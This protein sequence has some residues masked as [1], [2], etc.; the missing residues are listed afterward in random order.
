[1]K[2]ELFSLYYILPE[3]Q[4]K[5]PEPEGESL[6]AIEA[7]GAAAAFAILS[8]TAP[9]KPSK[10]DDDGEKEGEEGGDKSANLEKAAEKASRKT[11]RR[12]KRKMA[13]E[14][15]VNNVLNAQT[16]QQLMDEVVVFENA[17]PSQ[18]VFAYN[19]PTPSNNTAYSLSAVATRLYTI[20]RSLRYDDLK[21]AEMQSV[22]CAYKL[23]TQFAMRCFLSAS[24]TRF[25]CHGGKCS[26]FVDTASR[27]PDMLEAGMPSNMI[28]AGR[29]VMQF[30]A[31]DRI[32]RYPGLGA[33][34]FVGHNL[35]QAGHMNGAG[36]MNAFRR[37]D[38]FNKYKDDEYEFVEPARKPERVQID[39]ENIQPYIPAAH[40]ISQSEWI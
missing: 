4:M 21:G 33:G 34:G 39:I 17:I 13:I 2:A 37:P 25:M 5:W 22:M 28:A 10:D 32:N 26:N 15:F 31:Q 3:K 14:K 1:L 23:R 27:I 36:G 7:A 9:V 24:C 6:A 16:P 35:L 30:P 8:G 20:D 29:P 11:K 38:S 18:H 19:K 40:E 12:M